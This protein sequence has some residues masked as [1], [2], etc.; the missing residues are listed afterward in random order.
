MKKLLI[1]LLFV[2]PYLHAA[3]W[4]HKTTKQLMFS[5]DPIASD[6]VNWIKN[7]P[8]IDNVKDVPVYYRK[9]TADNTDIV[10]MDAA[11]KLSVDATLLG[12]W[13]QD[14]LTEIREKT[15][16]IIKSNVFVYNGKVYATAYWIFYDALTMAKDKG[17]ITTQDIAT[18]YGERIT[19]NALEI[20][21][22]Y[23]SAKTAMI[24]IM[25]DQL[26]LTDQVFQAT[27]KAELDAV[28]DNR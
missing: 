28:V 18:V 8:S 4:A 16:E 25:A 3:D 14:R 10:E 26:N 6:Q 17:K 13:K 7:P 15:V 1:L 12:Q 20:E 11:E 23:D 2:F 9:V 5:N 24:A 22:L 21:D 19:L 27:T